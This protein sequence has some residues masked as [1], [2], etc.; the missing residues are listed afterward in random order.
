MKG[1]NLEQHLIF[2]TACLNFVLNRTCHA[3]LGSTLWQVFAFY[4]V[5]KTGVAA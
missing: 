4:K 2:K 3:S 5:A 1:E